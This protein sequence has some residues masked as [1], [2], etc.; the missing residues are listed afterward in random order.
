M[1]YDLFWD[2]TPFCTLLYVD[3]RCCGRGHGGALMRRWEADM[4]VRGYGLLMTSTLADET[5]QHFYCKL[6]YHGA[7]GLLLDVSGYEQPMELFLIKA[8]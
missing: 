4:K 5:A 2:N 6:G 7:G 1:R 8:I 3:E